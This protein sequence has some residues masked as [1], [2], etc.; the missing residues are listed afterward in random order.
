MARQKKSGLWLGIVFLIAGAFFLGSVSANVAM[1]D[2]KSE[3]GA[4]NLKGVPQT[5]SQD[6]LNKPKFLFEFLVPVTL[7]NINSNVDVAIVSCLVSG[8]GVSGDGHGEVP[9]QGNSYT[10][11]VSVYITKMTNGKAF[12]ATGWTCGLIF[13]TPGGET[14]ADHPRVGIDSIWVTHAPNTPMNVKLSGL[15]SDQ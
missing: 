13:S 3:T 1:A 8:G 14:L 5:S 2:S 7:N 6:A 4:T 11:T 12:D 15:F 10:G 9:L